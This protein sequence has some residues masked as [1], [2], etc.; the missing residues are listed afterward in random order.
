[1]VASTQNRTSAQDA[2]FALEWQHNKYTGSSDK[3]ESSS[4]KIINMSPIL[5]QS[6]YT[7][8]SII[9]QRSCDDVT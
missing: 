6:I 3:A 2:W 1:M 5:N 7:V 9:V 8:R 4:Q